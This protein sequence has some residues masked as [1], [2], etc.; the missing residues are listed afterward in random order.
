MSKTR[1]YKLKERQVFPTTIA[2]LENICFN[3]DRFTPQGPTKGFYFGDRVEK[4]VELLVV[5]P[6]E[7]QNILTELEMFIMYERYPNFDWM[8]EEKKGRKRREV[9]ILARY[10]AKERFIATDDPRWVNRKRN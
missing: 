1:I 10:E 5:S 8:V 9:Q 4:D 7:Y 2:T 6:N 3:K